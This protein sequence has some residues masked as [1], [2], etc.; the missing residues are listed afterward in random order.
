MSLT[1]T[2]TTSGLQLRIRK[3]QL[4]AAMELGA[5]MKEE[6][7]NTTTSRWVLGK[8]RPGEVPAAVKVPG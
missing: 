5:K 4:P 2:V 7:A 8:D 6:H 1:Q 3:W